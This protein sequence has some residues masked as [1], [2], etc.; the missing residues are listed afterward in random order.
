MMNYI[1]LDLNDSTTNIAYS[2]YV[3]FVIG[4]KCNENI[5]FIRIFLFAARALHIYFLLC[6]NLFPLVIWIYKFYGV[7]WNRFLYNFIVIYNFD[8]L[9][10]IIVDQHKEKP[11]L[12]G[13]INDVFFPQ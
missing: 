13:C 5:N 12:T 6:K 4:L 10:S 2:S 7:N 1:I 11:D 9:Y 8:I 3:I